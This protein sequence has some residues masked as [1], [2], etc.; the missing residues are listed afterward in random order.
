MLPAGVHSLPRHV[1]AFRRLVYQSGMHS[2][3]KTKKPE[4]SGEGSQNGDLC[5][6]SEQNVWSYMA[7]EIGSE[8]Q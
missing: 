3:A 5:L 1:V 6:L 8:A 4:L 7:V 2:A